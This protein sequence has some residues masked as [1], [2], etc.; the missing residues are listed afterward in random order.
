MKKRSNTKKG[1]MELSISTIVVIV[2]A[3]SMLIL[4]LVL[5]RTIFTGATESVTEI[6][7]K[8]K[9]EIKEMFVDD[10][11]KI[12]VKLDSDKTIR[13]RADGTMSGVGFGARTIDGSIVDT[14][15]MKYKLNLDT[16]SRENCVS[17]L[18]IKKVEEF[19]KQNIGTDM[20]L[21]E[22]EGDTAFAAIQISIPEGTPLCSQKVFIDVWDGDTPIGRALFIIEVIRKGFF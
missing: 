10:S 3:M 11:T 8:I 1:A 16:N 12:I 5:V 13:I 17:I 19:F 9:G 21:D 7:T 22:F 4:G 14:K 2:L 6:D 20:P 15:E 18:N